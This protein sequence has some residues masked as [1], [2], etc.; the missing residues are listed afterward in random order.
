[1]NNYEKKEKIIDEAKKETDTKLTD[2]IA[3]ES[4]KQ[5]QMRIS[6]SL[7]NTDSI[8][9]IQKNQKKILESFQPI[10]EKQTNMKVGLE[11]FKKSL[12]MSVS[13]WNQMQEVIKILKKSF[14]F[15]HNI[16]VGEFSK[17]IYRMTAE[18]SEVIRK[19]KI[20]SI[21][22]KKKQELLEIHRLWGHYGWTINPCAD[23]ETLFSS[24]PANKKDADIMALK[25]CPNKIMEQIFEVLL[26][27]KRTKKTDFRE[28]VFDYRHKQ[29][30]SCAFIL[31]ALID[32]ILIRL[33]KK[34]TLDGKRRNVGLSAVRDAKK[35][36]EIDVNTE[37][38]YTALFCTNLFACL[39]KV[40]ESGNDFRKQPEVINRN[41]LDH[42]MLTRKVT[43]KDCMQLF[44]LYYNMLKLLE[45]IY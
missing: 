2:S 13:K 35:R 18:F 16:E 36:T 21:S 17:A 44:L 15:S 23:E 9:Q 14:K 43:K 45:L 25:Q 19:I 1:M 32:A 4:I 34:S 5:I 27:N 12:G 39:Q 33:Q 10:L 40:F 8:K 28:A 6:S 7:R 38:L 31:F 41:F 20:P 11:N 24:M 26:E 30:K 29:Y 22:E 37:V 3:N 42:G